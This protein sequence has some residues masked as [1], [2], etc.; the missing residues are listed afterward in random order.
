MGLFD[1]VGMKGPIENPSLLGRAGNAMHQLHNSSGWQ[2]AM[3]INRGE[4]PAQN[5]LIREQIKTSQQARETAAEQ[6]RY[7]KMV[8]EMQ[9]QGKPVPPMLAFRAGIT[10]AEFQML[11]PE[12]KT[13]TDQSGRLR[14][15]DDQS[16]AFDASGT[17]PK[18][19]ELAF[20][21]EKKLRGEFQDLNKSFRQQEEAFGRIISSAEDPSAAGDLALIFNYMKVLDPGSTVRE[22]EFANAENSGGV[23]A[24]VSATYNK[25]VSGERLT[26]SMRNDFLNRAVKLYKGAGENFNRRS[27]QYKG[28]AGQ[29]N[30]TPNRVVSSQQLYG[31]DDYNSMSGAPP[32]GQMVDGY[33]YLGGDPAAPESWEIQ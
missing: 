24:K 7:R 27:E 14:Y 30:L 4:N 31:D 2:D 16:P 9:G 8:D 1:K 25:L 13:A 28:L 23:G 15:L 19:D 29:Y 6:A 11:N 21:Q 22:G 3:S 12:R 32:V 26:P 10:P 5:R 20:D 18:V 33:T 17:N